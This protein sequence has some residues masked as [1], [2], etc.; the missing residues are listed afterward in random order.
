MKVNI[1]SG[2]LLFFLISCNNSNKLYD[3]Y[4]NEFITYYPNII[5][6]NVPNTFHRITETN[7]SK[8]IERDAQNNAELYINLV[9][10]NELIETCNITFFL[11]LVI[12]L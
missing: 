8:I 11:Y 7:Y 5:G 9:V 2:I 4:F 3:K 10:K 12:T 6:N 1:I